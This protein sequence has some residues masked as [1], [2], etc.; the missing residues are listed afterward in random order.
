M[1]LQENQTKQTV[2]QWEIKSSK[3][4]PML[5]WGVLFLSTQSLACS[6][7]VV[8]QKVP[9]PLQEANLRS[10]NPQ[11]MSFYYYFLHILFLRYLVLLFFS[12]SRSTMYLC[13]SAIYPFLVFSM[14]TV[15]INTK[16]YKHKNGKEA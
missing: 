13:T 4:K 1:Q 9:D 6:K 11:S 7:H 10:K 5:S 12:V 14:A 16:K 8:C 2:Q 15:S 3:E